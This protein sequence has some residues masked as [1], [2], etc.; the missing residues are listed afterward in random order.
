MWNTW[1]GTHI[2]GFDRV[3]ELSP[4]DI[5]PDYYEQHR[6]ILDVPRGN[7]PETFYSPNYAY[8][9]PEHPLDH[10]GTVLFLHKAKNPNPLTLLRECYITLRSRYRYRRDR[11]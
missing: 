6:D 8:H 2:A 10:Y 5:A 9:V 11:G 7:W 4:S 1:T 3:Y